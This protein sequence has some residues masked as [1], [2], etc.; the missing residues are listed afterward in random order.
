MD[1]EDQGKATPVVAGSNMPHRGDAAAG[2]NPVGDGSGGGGAHGSRVV[3]YQLRW[4]RP[5]HLRE[6]VVSPTMA[7]D[8]LTGSYRHGL[9]SLTHTGASGG[10]SG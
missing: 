9:T 4:V 5:R 8:H 2:S 3:R 6:I 7:T 10:G 1:L